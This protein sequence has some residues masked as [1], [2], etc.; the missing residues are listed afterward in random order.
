MTKEFP[1]NIQ[2]PAQRYFQVPSC[3]WSQVF[4]PTFPPVSERARLFLSRTAAKRIVFLSNNARPP[5]FPHI[6]FA[7][8]QKRKSPLSLCGSIFTSNPMT[9]A[10]ELFAKTAKF[11]A[12]ST[13]PQN[14][15]RLEN[16]GNRAPR[17]IRHCRARDP[18]TTMHA[19][20]NAPENRSDVR[21]RARRTTLRKAHPQ[22]S[23]PN[24]KETPYATISPK[25]S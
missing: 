4:N 9:S 12:K 22:R 15:S 11:F 25:L 17:P 1:R 10:Q 6:H 7:D 23:L 3:V 21:D 24:P 14:P 2:E 18:A 19:A 16:A 8:F 13:M 5:Y 20:S